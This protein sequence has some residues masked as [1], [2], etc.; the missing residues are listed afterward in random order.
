M[1]LEALNQDEAF[2]LGV[3]KCTCFVF[4]EEQNFDGR[5]KKA[6]CGTAFFVS[7]HLLLTAG[8][9]AM[10]VNGGV[11]EIR[12]TPPGIDQMHSWQVSRGGVHSIKCKVLATLYRQGGK[13]ENDIAILDTLPY[14]V[15]EYL[16]LS[17]ISPA[18]G[19]VLDVIGYAGE[20]VLEWINSHGVQ[21]VEK[22][23][24]EVESLFTDGSLTVTRGVSVAVGNTMTYRLS[25]CPGMGGGCVLYKGSVIGKYKS[26]SSLKIRR[27]YRAM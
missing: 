16:P 2:I 5:Y 4:M 10:S 17:S 23:R 21:D 25:T 20:I 24:M 3:A 9:N 26:G 14:T 13:P 19:S 18:S 12:I 27:T 6:F 7:S 22:R 11:I 8:H 1:V 15:E